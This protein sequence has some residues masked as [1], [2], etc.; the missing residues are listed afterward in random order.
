[1]PKGKG[2]TNIGDPQ[3]QLANPIEQLRL[4]IITK[5]RDGT[6]DNDNDGRVGAAPQCCGRLAGE[7]LPGKEQ[8]YQQHRC[9]QH[10]EIWR[11][12]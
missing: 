11:C 8:T 4:G 3:H 6:T 12:N 9:C 7:Y 2:R 1:M 10:N 5:G